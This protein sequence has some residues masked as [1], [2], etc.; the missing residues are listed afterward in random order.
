MDELYQYAKKINQFTESVNSKK[1]AK[2]MERLAFYDQLTG[3][4]NRGCFEHDC[5]SY[6]P[7]EMTAIFIDANGLKQTNDTYGH[8]AGDALLIC[9]SQT[10]QEVWSKDSAYRVGGDEFW[11]ILQN[12]TPEKVANEIAD[13]KERLKAQPCNGL[14]VSCAI[15]IA[16]GGADK[17]VEQIISEADQDMYR[18]KRQYKK[19]RSDFVP[20]VGT[21]SAES[22]TDTLQ[23]LADIVR[24]AI[25]L[26][27]LSGILFFIN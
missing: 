26:A 7:K 4:K 25:E 8:K 2:K 11:V 23:I 9:I 14:E 10:I 6:L 1:E 13:F 20:T 3:L 5:G 27:V 12:R 22:E 21:K 18:D 16:T 15:G 24:N 17:T 19:E